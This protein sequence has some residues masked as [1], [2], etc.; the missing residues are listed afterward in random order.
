M[1]QPCVV[2]PVLACGR[3]SG[4]VVQPGELELLCLPGRLGISGDGVVE[5]L[6][7]GGLLPG[8]VQV[9]LQRQNEQADGLAG[10]RPQASAVVRLAYSA[11]VATCPVVRARGSAGAG[12]SWCSRG[13]RR[14]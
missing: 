7:P 4:E 13:P 10:P 5:Q 2:E 9:L 1:V 6:P 11:R 8:L 12:S 14:V 3:N